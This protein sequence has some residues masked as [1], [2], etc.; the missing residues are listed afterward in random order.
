MAEQSK[1]VD[2]SSPSSGGR[3]LITDADYEKLDN[4]SGNENDVKTEPKVLK[5]TDQSSDGKS[6]TSF[7]E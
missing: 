5:M 6:D 1:R 2:T 4:L 7:D 3:D